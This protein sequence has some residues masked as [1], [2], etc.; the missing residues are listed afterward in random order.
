MRGLSIRRCRGVVRGAVP[1]SAG[2]SR[3]RTRRL[4]HAD[5]G[6]AC[7]A[8]YAKMVPKARIR[9]V[10]VRR[11][12][13]GLLRTAGRASGRRSCF[14]PPVVR[15]R[16]SLS[17]GRSGRVAV[18][19]FLC[20]QRIWSADSAG[21]RTCM[22]AAGAAGPGTGSV[23]RS[24]PGRMLASGRRRGTARNAAKKRRPAKCRASVR[25]SPDACRANVR[26][27][28]RGVRAAA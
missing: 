8:G 24:S 28:W 1:E 7:D 25:V 2:L 3:R 6:E 22:R 4:P 20:G 9:A 26:P 14:G 27:V 15:G 13:P 23:R 16:R 10:G 18:G 21:G 19:R 11:G 5:G 17:P 12:C